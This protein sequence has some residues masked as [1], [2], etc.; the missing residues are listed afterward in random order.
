MIILNSRFSPKGIF[1][2]F[3]GFFYIDSHTICK[4]GQFYFVLYFLANRKKIETRYRNG[5]NLVHGLVF[6]AV[7]GD[8]SF[9]GKILERWGYE[10]K[11][12]KLDKPMK[13][14]MI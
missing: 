11:A 6:E 7:I 9:R 3:L 5:F 4:Y 1:V 14:K 12:Y 10:T 13:V 2:D 8:L